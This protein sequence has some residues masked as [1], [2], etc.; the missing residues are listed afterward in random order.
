MLHVRNPEFSETESFIVGSKHACLLH[1][2]TPFSLSKVV[3]DTDVFE[4]AIYNK[5]QT[6]KA[7][8]I[9]HAEA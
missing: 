7:C 3:H 6:L 4:K 8:L 9:R 1:T 5:K 2:E